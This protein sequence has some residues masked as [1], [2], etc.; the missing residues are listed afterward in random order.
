M[1]LELVSNVEVTMVG[2]SGTLPFKM[3][4][5]AMRDFKKGE[6]V[7]VPFGATP[8]PKED[9]HFGH[10]EKILGAM[11]SRASVSAR[12]LKKPSKNDEGCEAAPAHGT[13]WIGSPLLQGKSPKHR[14][15][16]CENLAPFWAIP[17]TARADDNMLLETMIFEVPGFVPLHSITHAQKFPNLARGNKFM[18]EVDVM[19]NSKRIASGELLYLPFRDE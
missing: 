19:R 18:M 6:L 5:K 15:T 2:P 13:F 17:Q 11:L 16:C 14:L 3:E 8:T 12:A 1:T 9:A 10:D 4:V 7:L